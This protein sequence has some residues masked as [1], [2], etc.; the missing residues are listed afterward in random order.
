LHGTGD[1]DGEFGDAT[2]SQWLEDLRCGLRWLESQR[3][4]PV[5]IWGVRLGAILAGQL[6]A[7]EAA[8]DRLLLW[9]PVSQ[10][11][12]FLTNLLRVRI[13][14][15]MHDPQGVKTT[16]QLRAAWAAHQPVDLSGYHVNPDLAA[17]IEQAELSATALPMH[18]KVTWCEVVPTTEAAIPRA[19]EK[20]IDAWRAAGRTIDL[21]TVVGAPFWQVHEREL[22]PALVEAS[23][24]AASSWPVLAPPRVDDRTSPRVARA[25]HQRPIVF[26]C[27]SDEL[28]G[29]YHAGAPGSDSRRGVVIVVAG[30]PQYRV[31][32][33]RQFVHL[34]RKL[35][36]IGYPV[37]R[38]DLRGMGDSTGAY[39]GYQQSSSDI[40]AAVDALLQQE[41][42]I[43]EVV[44]FGECESASGI[45]FYAWR[46]SRI[47]GIALVNPWVRTEEG[48]AQVIVKHYYGE[49]LRSVEFWRKVFSGQFDWRGSLKSLGQTLAAF[50]RGKRAFARSRSADDA[51]DIEG[52]PLPEKTAAGLR[53]YGGQV[54]LL[55]S[56]RDYIAQEFDEVTSESRAWE[57]LL[58]GP[59]LRR[60]DVAGADHTFSRAEWKDE[61]STAVTDW[62]KSW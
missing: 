42:G 25:T 23:A 36:A 53:R 2:W 5:S 40:R 20:L 27:Q 30:G 33:H 47:K 51:V 37:L 7:T 58:Q 62:L 29:V 24:A 4:G 15:E 39:L 54:L 52:L 43:Q 9:Q 61:A 14:A 46:D 32:A 16:D 1:S 13:A 56:G 49:R 22:A 34:A 3:L 10:G 57:G 48:R 26:A 11:K 50:Y 8:I 35:A 44:L 59:R 38:F 18:V 41:P 19:S 6:V 17:A 45:L 55:M 60:H 28:A 12:Q 31:G 21:V